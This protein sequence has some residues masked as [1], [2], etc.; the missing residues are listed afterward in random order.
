MPLNKREIPDPFTFAHP[1]L[2]ADSTA[3]EIL[4]DT[5]FAAVVGSVGQL[6]AL[7]AYATEI[8]DTILRIANET[9][10]RVD[11]TTA[12]T[13]ALI[14]DIDGTEKQVVAASKLEKPI[15]KVSTCDRANTNQIPTVLTKSTNDDAVVRLYEAAQLPP[16]LWK[17]DKDYGAGVTMDAYSNPGLFFKEWIKAETR[18][19]EQERKA[20]KAKRE[21][22]KARK[23]A[24]RK[25]KKER[26]SLRLSLDHGGD[27]SMVGGESMWQAYSESSKKIMHHKRTRAKGRKTKGRRTFGE[28]L[29]PVSEFQPPSVDELPAANMNAGLVFELSFSDWELPFD[30]LGFD[31]KLPRVVQHGEGPPNMGDIIVSVNGKEI[32]GFDSPHARLLELIQT[33]MRPLLFEFEKATEKIKLPAATPAYEEFHDDEQS[34]A[35]GR[36]LETA[37]SDTSTL[38]DGRGGDFNSLYGN[39]ATQAS[40]LMELDTDEGTGRDTVVTAHAAHTP[41]FDPEVQTAGLQPPPPPAAPAP[42]DD[43]A[44]AHSEAG[45]GQEE[46]K[47]TRAGRPSVMFKMDATDDAATASGVSSASK[48]TGSRKSTSFLD[49]P[50]LDG[51]DEDF[52]ALDDIMGDSQMY[53]ADRDRRTTVTDEVEAQYSPDGVV[54]D[55]AD[56]ILDGESSAD[57]SVASAAAERKSEARRRWGK[58]RNSLGALKAMSLKQDS[59]V[60]DGDDPAIDVDGN[61]SVQGE[62]EGEGGGED[63]GR[64]RDES[65]VSSVEQNPAED[66]DVP[67]SARGVVALGG[68]EG[69][70]ANTANEGGGDEHKEENARGEHDAD[71]KGDED[72][73]EE[74]GKA[75]GEGGEGDFSDWEEAYTPDGQVY[76]V[77]MVTQESSWTDPRVTGRIGE[78]D[79]AEAE[80]EEETEEETEEEE[81][82]STIPIPPPLPPED[83][84]PIKKVK[85]RAKM[86]RRSSQHMKKMSM[87]NLHNSSRP[88]MGRRRSSMVIPGQSLIGARRESTTPAAPPG[89][90][91]E[92]LNKSKS[93]L[94]KAPEMKKKAMDVRSTDMKS[95]L[96]A[97]KEKGMRKVEINAHHND[98]AH[99]Q[100]DDAVAKILANRQAIE[101]TDSE[102]DSDDSGSE[103]TDSD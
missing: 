98:N 83:F 58:I 65:N 66:G 72:K 91:M 101:D 62:G 21:A 31:P 11:K 64:S 67:D 9:R 39:P 51:H 49:D 32:A 7:S 19:Q 97:V 3:E 23:K 30:I 35:S 47:Q 86:S 34:L 50:T 18:R 87:A 59:L 61:P 100:V 68:E 43:P 37:V 77:N 96:K 42:P 80:A 38:I 54:P 55:N 88:S 17:F 95:M 78:Q 52:A 73:D 92:M 29:A 89:S 75:Q 76:Y 36:T 28:S 82:I 53:A 16:E 60:K 22:E 71:A 13:N 14:R 93:G 57:P 45:A 48:T 41:T 69:S 27:Q 5:S 24:K 26:E 6:A 8:M 20:R 12:K 33:E 102:S 25:L 81:P 44:V 46:K 103:F 2:Y 63:D 79:E 10:V 90:L 99:I 40:A 4:D 84:E 74:E 94:K 56:E 85:K 15:T 70:E 1:G